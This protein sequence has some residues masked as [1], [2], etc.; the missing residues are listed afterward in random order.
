[1]DQPGTPTHPKTK[2]MK[3]NSL[4]KSFLYFLKKTISYILLYFGIGINL[5]DL[6]NS[7]KKKNKKKLAHACSKKVSFANKK[8]SYTHLRK[9]ASDNY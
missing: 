2:R 1:M 6:P 9:K 7:K 8:I 5:V 3:K 4:K